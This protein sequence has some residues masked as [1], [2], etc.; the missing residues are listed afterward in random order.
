MTIPTIDPEVTPQPDELASPQPSEPQKGDAEAADTQDDTV[1]WKAKAE[2]LAV[3]NLKLENDNKAMS[4]RARVARDQERDAIQNNILDTLDGLSKRVGALGARSASGEL[5]ELKGDMAAIDRESAQARSLRQWDDG[6]KHVEGQLMEALQDDEGNLVIDV[7]SEDVTALTQKWKTAVTDKDL[8][9][10][11]DVVT[12]ANK[13]ARR[14]ERTKATEQTDK[15]RDEERKAKEA[16]DKLAGIHD[17][18]VGAPA[19]GSG[20]GMSWTQA[21]KIQ[22]V[23]DISDEDYA[24]LVA[25]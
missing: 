20:S 5:E 10:L 1:D 18:G 19:A 14:I 13:L 16:S 15:V 4:G 6:Y 11:S 22:K 17:L 8:L 23:E 12:D 3:T 24:K 25:G 7:N 21:Q 9:A 2:E